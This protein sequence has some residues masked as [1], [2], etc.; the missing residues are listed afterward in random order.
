MARKYINPNRDTTPRDFDHSALAA[1]PA[2][3]ALRQ[4]LSDLANETAETCPSMTLTDFLDAVRDATV[5][6]PNGDMCREC[7][8][9]CGCDS[10]RAEAWPCD[11]YRLWWPH[12]VLRREH[13]YTG[14]YRCGSGHEWVCSFSNDY[15][16]WMANL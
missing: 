9:A 8:R 12:A 5:T 3:A 2:Y 15:T 11:H 6:A 13:G 14:R 1:A 4:A 16:R 10:T 7:N